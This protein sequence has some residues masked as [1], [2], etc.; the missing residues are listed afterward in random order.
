MSDFRFAFNE[1][2][3]FTSVSSEK[4]ILA[5]QI[6][7]RVRE[8]KNIGIHYHKINDKKSNNYDKFQ[9]IYHK[10]CGYC[11]VPVFINTA[12]QYEIDHFVNKLQKDFYTEKSVDHI[13]NLV[14]AC[15]NCN[16]AKKDFDIG[17][18]FHCVHPDGNVINLVFE[19]NEKYEIVISDQY[20]GES[21]IQRFYQKMNF[22]YLYRKLDY[23]LLNLAVYKENN[24]KMEK[25]YNK[26]RDLRN[27]TP[28][29]NILK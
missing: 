7:C 28:S 26:L 12:P 4:D 27:S 25:I 17:K 8:P 22:D 14:F 19:R 16:Q 23:L 21:E 15:K 9:E 5:S 13:D 29:L 6:D 11:G 3:D 20:K 18:I 2:N 10:K 1:A 24:E